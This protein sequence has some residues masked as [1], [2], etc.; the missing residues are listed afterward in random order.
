MRHEQLDIRAIDIRSLSP[1]Q[2]HALKRVM[3]RRAD[4]ARA[5]AMRH[6]FARVFGPLGW[7]RPA[8]LKRLIGRLQRAY[9]R[10]RDR[11]KAVAQLS[12]MTDYELRD[13][14]LSRME[15]KAAAW[16][17]GGDPTLSPETGRGVEPVEPLERHDRVG[18]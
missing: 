11:L 17:D 13:I 6:A 18:K 14:G 1:E 16:A 2:R 3:I 10:R 7:L 9:G 12:A 15:I 8:M 5:A 4:A